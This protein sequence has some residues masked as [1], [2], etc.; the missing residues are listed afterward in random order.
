MWGNGAMTSMA[1]LGHY[2]HAYLG[3]YKYGLTGP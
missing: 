1:Y 2:K 3:H